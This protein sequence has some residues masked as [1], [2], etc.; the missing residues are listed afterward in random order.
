[1]RRAGP[2]DPFAAL[3]REFELELRHLKQMLALAAEEQ[4]DLVAGDMNR[5]DAISA[6]KL[7]QLRALEHYAGRRA[8]CLAEQ[9]FAADARGLA[10]CA[11]AAGRRGHELTTAWKRVADAFAELRD[12]AEENDLLLRARL[13]A[14]CE[15]AERESGRAARPTSAQAWTVHP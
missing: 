7:V 1:M 12:A 15:P 8:A 5:L 10:A 11:L 14:L 6:E 4:R 13:A 2:A 9:G 3:V